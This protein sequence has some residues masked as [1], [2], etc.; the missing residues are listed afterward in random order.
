MLLMG[1]GSV[2]ARHAA[3]RSPAP[4]AATGMLLVAVTSEALTLTTA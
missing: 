2:L 3:R 4:M 1:A